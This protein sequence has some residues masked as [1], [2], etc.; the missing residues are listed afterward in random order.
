MKGATKLFFVQ[1]LIA[2]VLFG[3]SYSQAS[4]S[5]TVRYIDN[6]EPV[7]KGSVKAYNQSGIL[8]AATSINSNGT[9]MFAEL[10]GELLDVIGIPD[11]GPEDEDFIPTFY[12]DVTDWQYAVPIF[13]SSPLTNI[14]IYV[15]RPQG[16]DNPFVSNITGKVTLN[17]KPV[18]DAIV[19]VKSGNS[20]YGYG[21][22][23]SKGEYTINSIPLGDYILVVHRIGA[24][25]ATRNVN[26][27]MEGLTNVIFNLEEAPFIISNNTPKEY[28]LS[29]NYPNP[30][31]PATTIKYAVPVT[32]QV[33]MSVYNSMGQLVKVL[34]NE[35][36]TSGAY[37]V[38]FDGSD[39]ASGV[40]LYR[41]EAGDPVTGQFVET[42]KMILVK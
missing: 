41:L 1:L 32:G 31:N 29:Q 7:T 22:T 25:S 16:G 35:V 11:L 40:Y 4:V 27:T 5:G 21:I 13:P 17:N 39:L 26:L 8:V 10:P 24:S 34:V 23:N 2:F 9:Y 6:N 12:P 30:F 20:Y 15:E 28:E 33:K 36:Q 42:K 14:D 37:N 19:Y 38:S 3:S 18:D